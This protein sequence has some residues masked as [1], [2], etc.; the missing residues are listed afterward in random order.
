MGLMDCKQF[1]KY[2][3]AF[4]DGEL[5][6]EQNLDALDHLNMCPICAA[7]VTKVTALKETLMQA[8]GDVKAP[9]HLVERI[10]GTYRVGD[11]ESTR[12]ATRK[13]KPLVRVFAPLAA[14]AS[15][16]LVVGLWQPWITS[17][18]PILK[19]LPAQLVADVREQHRMCVQERGTNH[20]AP[21]L[22]RDPQALLAALQRDLHL[23]VAVPDLSGK[24]FTLIGVDRCGVAGRPGAHAL[25][26]STEQ[27]GEL[28]LF[29]I[30]RVATLVSD[31]VGRP[32][33]R[34]MI[35]SCDQSVLVVAWHHGRQT[36][37]ACAEL[38]E[39]ALRDLAEGIRTGLAVAE[40]V[41]RAVLALAY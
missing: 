14:A 29:T 17:P 38:S 2:I 8:Y 35:V 39:G 32:A 34:G 33:D 36:Y 19:V 10:T 7:R 25:Y 6:V 16:L 15:L 4:A 1:K 12:K 11:G 18:S 27:E 26:R 24:G 31:H 28:S 5:G 9:Q 23:A 22:P 20:F 41:S 37:L 21:D 13:T 30:A 3:G 40:P